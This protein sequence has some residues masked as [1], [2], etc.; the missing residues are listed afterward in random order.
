[1]DEVIV[2]IRNSRIRMSRGNQASID[3][4]FDEARILLDKLLKAILDFGRVD[5]EASKKKRITELEV[6]LN[7]LKGLT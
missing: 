7:N 2:L 5:V 4:T 6:E 3:V 1:M